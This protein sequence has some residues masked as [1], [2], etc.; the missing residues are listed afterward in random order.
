MTWS[1]LL[2]GAAAPL[3]LRLPPI[4][5]GFAFALQK[6]NA[7]EDG[8]WTCQRANHV[9]QGG[10]CKQRPGPTQLPVRDMIGRDSKVG[11]DARTHSLASQAVAGS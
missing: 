4:V 2:H 7:A 1:G 6:R 11:A 10:I 3:W 9:A 5:D 8:T